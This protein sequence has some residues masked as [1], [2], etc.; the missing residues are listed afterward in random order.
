MA[1]IKRGLAL[2]LLIGFS[3][4][5]ASAQD[6]TSG[7]DGLGSSA[8]GLSMDAPGNGNPS[9]I[10]PT[11]RT[12]VPSVT[13]DRSSEWVIAPIP[14]YSPAQE[15]ALGLVAQ[16]IFHPAGTDPSQPPSVIGGGGFVTQMGSYGG[17]LGYLGHLDNDRWRVT[18]GF[19]Y[20]LINYDFFGIGNASALQDHPI[21]IE[22][23]MTGVLLQLLGRIAP[24]VY[25]G[26]RLYG[27]DIN[28]SVKRQNDF[29]TLPEQ[30]RETRT[31]ALGGKLQWDTRDNTFYPTTGQ[32]MNL[33][34][35]ISSEAFGG[36]FNY[37]AYEGEYNH[38]QSLS[39]KDVLALRAYGRTVNG[40]VPFFD[41]SQ[42]GQHNDLRG[43]ESGKYRDKLMLATQGEIR[44]ML[45]DWLAIAAFAGIGE[46]APDVG[47]LTFDNLLWSVGGG[48]RFRIAKENPVNFRI[49]FAQGEDGGTFY[50][51]VGEAF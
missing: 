33:T 26:P 5:V 49:D 18:A 44:H 10:D 4:S 38:Y 8:A 41:L 30:E 42:F 24:N 37:Q 11:K 46:V 39:E 27:I 35:D 15:W 1:A 22:Q 51:S 7:P 32:L 16:Y 31:I 48:L 29:V 43:Y 40:D 2:A 3:E 36:D 14:N 6:V 25:L 47:S 12:P 13:K 17:G 19:G 50:I 21:E 23:Q 9:V 20:G 34:I 45:N 28:A